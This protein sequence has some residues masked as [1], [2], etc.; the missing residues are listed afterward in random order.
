MNLQFQYEN[1]HAPPHSDALN[2]CGAHVHPFPIFLFCTSRLQIDV[3]GPAIFFL[4]H[5]VKNYLEVQEIL[6]TTTDAKGQKTQS[7]DPRD[8]PS[9]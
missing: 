7:S 1:P 2:C 6:N 9:P 3:V 5:K 8:I 4:D